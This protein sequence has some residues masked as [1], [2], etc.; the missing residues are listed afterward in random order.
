MIRAYINATTKAYVRAVIP[1]YGGGSTNEPE[2]DTYIT[3]LATPL[4]AGQITKLNTFVS[5]LKTGMSITNLSDAFDVMYILGGET[6]ESSLKNLVKN[7]HHAT[8]VNSP[9]FTQ[10]EGFQG[11]GISKHI[12]TNYNPSTE[13]ER[14]S[15]N[16][17][18]FGIYYR[19]TVSDG[20]TKINGCWYNANTGRTTISLAST[21]INDSSATNNTSAITEPNV[22]LKVVSRSGSLVSYGT[23]NSEITNNNTLSTEIADS[24]IYLLAIYRINSSPNYIGYYDSSQI[25]F[26]FLG[27]GITTGEYAIIMSAFEAY[28]DANGKGVIA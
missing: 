15:L 4:S 5:A 3:G 24:D 23:Y 6:A 16:N 8:A 11:D 28:M 14:Y 2:V 27:R 18:S 9:T 26:S 25:S 20:L 22:G 1:D 13:A 21:A 17:A 12:K 19:K 10:Y 7:A